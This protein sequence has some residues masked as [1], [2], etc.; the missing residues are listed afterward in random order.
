MVF[1]EGMIAT[2]K[3]G[4]KILREVK[5]EGNQVVYLP[6]N[7][8]YS[9]LLKN[10]DT[11][12]AVVNIC[13]DNRDALGGSPIVVYPNS[14]TE[15]KGFIE[16]GSVKNAFR[17]IKKT[18]EVSDYRGNFLDDGVVH[19]EFRYEQVHEEKHIQTIHEHIYRPVS[20]NWYYW[21]PRYYTYTGPVPIVTWGST[22]SSPI[23]S[24]VVN[25][26]YNSQAGSSGIISGEVPISGN[27]NF[28][29]TSY[30]TDLIESDGITVP[31]QETHQSFHN[32]FM[33]KLEEQ[34][35]VINIVLK[36]TI[37]TG[38]EVVIPITTSDKFKC[39]SCGK[40]WPTSMKFCSSCGTALR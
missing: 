2:I 30:K 4:N 33:G 13:I 18:K 39:P 22:S 11:R 36:G 35:K 23:I 8:D 40:E 19:I 28:T 20:D 37:E 32:V 5:E 17:F 15:V 21:Y 14:E 3:C 10:K 1:K 38:T 26:S 25:C 24:D 16:N 27:I 31:G 29:S 7:S 34:G 6:F 9:I 12:K